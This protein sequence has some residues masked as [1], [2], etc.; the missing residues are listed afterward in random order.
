ME[1]PSRNRS[2]ADTDDGPVAEGGSTR[3]GTRRP[4]HHYSGW[5]GYMRLERMQLAERASG[6]MR[7]AIGRTLKGEDEGMLRRKADEDE[8]LARAGMVPLRRGGEAWL[9]HI[10]ELTPEDRWARI[11]AEK[12]TI[13]WLRGRLTAERVVETW[14][15]NGW[16]G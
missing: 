10:D 11:E 6:K 8:R 14:R 12:T 9:K 13:A 5:E 15:E 4:D 7:R 1:G 3:V 2:S 16:D